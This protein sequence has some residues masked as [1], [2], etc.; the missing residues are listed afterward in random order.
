MLDARILAERR[1]EIVESCRRRRVTADVDGAIA[2]RE[3]VAALQTELQQ[4]NRSR[5]EH[6]SAG[7]MKLADKEREAHVSEGRRIKDEVG[8][9][10]AQLDEAET[11]LQARL[12]EIP[13]FIHPDVPIGG[14]EDFREIRRVGSPRDF[15][16]DPVDHLVICDR[17]DLVDFEGGARVTGQKFYFL[18]NEM[19]LLDLALQRFALNIAIEAGFVPHTT[20]DLARRTIV[21]AMA[22]SP[23]G[24]ETQIYS[25][26]G[27]DL[28]LVGTAEITLGGLYADALLQETDL[29]LKLVGISHCFR[30]EAGAHGRESKG[31]YRV[32]QFTKVEMFVLCRPE[33]SEAMHEQIL[34]IEERILQALEIPYRVI[35]V[36]SGDLGA[37]AYRKYDIEA[38]MPGR[39]EAGDF[40]EVTSAS[41]CTDFQAR[42]LKARFRR[43]VTKKN[44]LVHTLNGTAV[45]LS[46][47]P[48]ALLE[49]HQ[50]ADGS[51]T[52]PKA[53]Q[54]NT[55][56]DRI[57]PR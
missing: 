33:D 25:V 22:F 12:A 45:A 27:T 34:K 49:N 54:P 48:V 53:L 19:V 18:K 43:A 3:Q 56:F 16:F 39:G 14:E 35:D 37:P 38:W 44:E 5:K 32:H 50:Q 52:I 28:D 2:A 47:T 7:K 36:A 4:L 26:E 29:P 46:R 13:N 21:D 10:E 51:V 42:R 1:D 6:Q 55:G 9:V 24:E 40:G 23:R 30:T 31:L 20:P 8:A 41:N 57:G 17:L 15:D 11:T